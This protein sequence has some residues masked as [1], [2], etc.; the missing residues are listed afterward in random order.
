M[1]EPSAY[2]VLLAW[3]QGRTRHALDRSLVLYALAAP[4]L[5]LEELADR[6]LGQRNAALLG[7]RR[8]LF[9]DALV[10]CVDCPACGE[11]LEFSVSAS[12]LLTQAGPSHAQVEVEGF[13]FRVP[14]TRDLAGVASDLDAARAA[15]T[16]LRSLL[17]TPRNLNEQ[18]ALAL[19][20]KVAAALEV[21][22]P[23]LDFVLQQQCP[24]CGHQWPAPFDVA[25]FVW[26]E[27]ETRARRLLDEVHVL[28]RAYGWAETEILSLT[29]ARRSAYLERVLA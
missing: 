25:G 17:A 8:S 16:L 15:R 10:A 13:A 7:L 5:E 20:P 19:V 21:A 6:P 14:T 2:S 28:A 4:D 12:A 22:D 27:V 11:K 9:G 26:D 23:C 1:Q 29:E 3:E 18:T 24:A